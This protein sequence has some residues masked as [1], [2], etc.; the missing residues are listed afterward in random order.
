M[1]IEYPSTCMAC[2]AGV[3]S[4]IPI[5]EPKKLYTAKHI[6]DRQVI[7]DEI[8][9][10]P[11]IRTYSHSCA[12]IKKDQHY[13]RRLEIQGK[14][15]LGQLNLWLQNG[16]AVRVPDSNSELEEL[17]E[18][19]TVRCPL[20]KV[21]AGKNC[22]RMTSAGKPAKVEN[23]YS[24]AERYNRKLMFTGRE[25]I[26]IPWWRDRAYY[27]KNVILPTGLIDEA[28]WKLGTHCYIVKRI[29]AS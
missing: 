1:E 22:L 17:I 24:H 7:D 25:V 15:K 13:R 14:G 3:Y 21:V 6:E 29:K 12:Q 8:R 9:L 28:G 19:K 11:I 2:G 26:G 23:R 4:G 27:N 5:G 20:C 18:P 16:T 10:V